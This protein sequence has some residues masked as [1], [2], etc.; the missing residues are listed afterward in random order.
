MSFQNC[1]I[2]QIGSDSRLYHDPGD[3]LPGD[4]AFVMGSSSLRNFMAC[5]ARF[6]SGYQ[7]PPTEAKDFGNLLDCVLLTPDQFESRYAV[8]PSLYEVDGEKR[9]WNNNANVCKDWRKAQGGREIIT[10]G[11]EVDAADCCKSLRRDEAIAT[12]LDDSCKQVWMTGEWLDE[13]TGLVIPC[14]CLIDLLPGVDS[15]YSKCLG[16]LKTTRNASLGAWSRWCHIAG[17]YIQAAWY[18][19]MYVAATGQDRTDFCFLLVENYA[20]WQTAKRLLSGE[21]L[22]LGRADIN[23]A[24]ALYARCLKDNFWPGYDDTDEAA[25]GG[26][27]IVAP[28][29]WMAG[30]AMFAPRF[31]VGEPEPEMEEMT[32]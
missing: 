5:P 11:E 4:P 10:A 24:M 20:P 17:Y 8:R 6:R 31:E 25:P 22:T 29:P 13:A 2:R 14:K 30:R 15:V 28:E 12:F 27:S 18:L 16:D 7:P 1:S 3:M 23:A 19:D 32:P 21:F 26:W 9:K